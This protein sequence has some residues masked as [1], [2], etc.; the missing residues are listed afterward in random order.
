[1]NDSQLMGLDYVSIEIYDIH[2]YFRMW[3]VSQQTL[4]F[5]DVTEKLPL[6][7]NNHT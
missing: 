4:G 2:G 1:M 7:K 6:I 3:T 5:W